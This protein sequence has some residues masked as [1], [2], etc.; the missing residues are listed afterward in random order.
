MD[1][2]FF[3][4]ITIFLHL[5]LQLAN[6]VANLNSR[7]L[8]SFPTPN[9]HMNNWTWTTVSKKENCYS[10]YQSFKQICYQNRLTF[11]VWTVSVT[12]IVN[13]DVDVLANCYFITKDDDC[14]FV[15]DRYW[16]Y[17]LRVG[18]EFLIPIEKSDLFL[19]V[20]CVIFHNFWE[21]RTLFIR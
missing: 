14:W 3:V 18:G 2:K 12:F 6:S 20:D 8:N 15:V 5:H 10:Y 1:N 13:V 17:I 16:F 21:F 11:I 9:R 7:I 4:V 19:L